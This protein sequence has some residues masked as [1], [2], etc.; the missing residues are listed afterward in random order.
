MR[1]LVRSFKDSQGVDRTVVGCSSLFA[2]R[3][4]FVETLK[5]E[6][7]K[8]CSRSV[9]SARAESRCGAAGFL[10]IVVLHVQDA[11][12][13]RLRSKK[14]AMQE[15][16]RRSRASNVLANVMVLYVGDCQI[17]VPSELVPLARKNANTLATALDIELR[18]VCTGAGLASGGGSAPA[19]DGPWTWFLY[20]IVQDGVLP[21]WQRLH[22]CW[23]WSVPR[24]LAL[25]HA[26]FWWR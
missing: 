10:G 22:S 13:L 24:P 3:G 19:G 7:E 18:R 12:D 8:C 25:A 21:I 11:A 5:D 6:A 16:P 15:L 4:A 2:I 17:A 9:A 14:L 26:T 20:I 23:Q 1:S